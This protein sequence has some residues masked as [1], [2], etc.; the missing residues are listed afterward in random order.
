M[1]KPGFA[2]LGA[3]LS[4]RRAWIE[5]ACSISP[6]NPVARRSPQGER[7]LKFVFGLERGEGV[8]R[9][10]PQGER[11]LKYCPGMPLPGR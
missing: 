6:Y 4:A 5:I 9:R 8:S 10:S 7:G 11:G 1:D 2:A 3:S